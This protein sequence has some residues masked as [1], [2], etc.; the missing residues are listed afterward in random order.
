MYLLFAAIG[1]IIGSIIFVL[2][3]YRVLVTALVCAAISAVSLVR[4][5]SYKE[6]I[7]TLL[8]FVLIMFFN[9]NFRAEHLEYLDLAKYL[10]TNH[11][12]EFKII[13]PVMKKIG[14]Q[15]EFIVEIKDKKKSIYNSLKNIF[16]PY[17]FLARTYSSK[18]LSQG[19]IIKINSELDFEKL[20]YYQGK[21][22]KKDKV[23]FQLKT[24]DIEFQRNSFSPF[25]DLRKKVR[26]Y[27]I[28]SLGKE[29]A[30]I[31][32]SLLFGSRIIELPKSLSNAIRSLGLGHFFAASGF[33]LVVLVGFITFILNKF[34]LSPLLNSSINSVIAIIYSGLA[35]FS[36]SIVRALICV[37][38]YFL[39]SASNRKLNSINLITLLAG[40]VIFIDPYTIFDLGFQF[41]YLATIALLIWTKAIS[42]RFT[43]FKNKILNGFTG[44]KILNNILSFITET[45]AV[46]LSVQIFLAPISIYYFKSFPIWGILANLFFT[47][48]LSLII[49]AS[50]L[51]LSFIISPLLDLVLYIFK[52]SKHLAFIHTQIEL[53][54]GA[55][56][57]LFILLSL[58][59]FDFAYPHIK[60]KLLEQ[61]NYLQA[62]DNSYF[63]KIL[64][65]SFLC[66]FLAKT[67]PVY[68]TYSYEIRYGKFD[69]LIYQ[70][71]QILKNKKENF[72]YFQLKDL[73]ALIIKDLSSLK[74]LNG[75]LDNLKEVHV[76]ILPKLRASDIYLDT[77]VHKLK[78][79]F[80]FTCTKSNSKKVQH[81]LKTLALNSNLIVN[82]GKLIISDRKFWKITE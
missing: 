77:L 1:S 15:S 48:I 71:L 54:L 43:D 13:S 66:L 39:V 46:S 17:R 32:S 41:S 18:A 23:F 73:K 57:L 12:V 30:D 67:L 26:R 50:F 42:K 40:I 19:D 5:N 34:K 63:R 10:S 49:V 72:K 65:L 25:S 64:S 35:G 22:Y 36:P 20:N 61:L 56:C 28:A 55:L 53:H 4:F 21:K 27:Y 2:D 59:A 14:F 82:E 78:P 62:F 3:D 44:N 52:V 11:T 80:I 37:L 7:H 69:K 79:Q 9:Y 75:L 51:G 81:N 45:L 60:K 8:A 24:K 33:H 31:C 16:I 70:E 76:L 47:P 74:K 58:I 29:K 68:S 38:A 6:K